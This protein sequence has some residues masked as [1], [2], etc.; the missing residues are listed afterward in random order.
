MMERVERTQESIEKINT[1]KVV[2]IETEDQ[3][4][5]GI[6]TETVDPDVRQIEVSA[7]EDM[8]GVSLLIK[9]SSLS[10]NKPFA[11]QLASGEWRDSTP[12]RSI[13]TWETSHSISF[14]D[15]VKLSEF[16]NSQPLPPNPHSEVGVALGSLKSYE[17]VLVPYSYSPERKKSPGSKFNFAFEKGLGW[18][19][20]LNATPENV[21]KISEYLKSN[22]YEHKYLSGGD[23]SDGKVFT[24]YFGSKSKLDEWSEVLASDLKSYISRPATNGEVE[25]APGISARFDPGQARGDRFF[26]YGYFGVP[27]YR[28]D[29]SEESVN[30]KRILLEGSTD[31]KEEVT[32]LS[33]EK[34]SDLYGSYFTG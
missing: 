29:T 20:H 10:P 30:S 21:K 22:E 27:V 31:E 6:L 17:S 24:I 5:R 28:G 23:P 4:I 8:K 34:L 18:K 14:A 32:R 3:V 2:Q 7:P 26:R 25:V 33:Y 12:L 11:Y 16:E 19:I 13:A 9:K 15:L 1:H